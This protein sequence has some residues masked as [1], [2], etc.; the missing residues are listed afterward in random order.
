ML[1]CADDSFYVGHTDNLERRITLHHSGELAGYTH[2]R[3]PVVLVWQQ[4]FATREEALAAERQVKGWGRA[5]KQA[6]I[7]GDWK[8]IRRHAWGTK[9][10]LPEHLK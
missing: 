7:E 6:L 3:R 8:A 9:N 4:D 1:R 5:K 10:P 2:K